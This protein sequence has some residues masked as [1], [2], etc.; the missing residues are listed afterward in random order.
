MKRSVIFVLSAVL[1]TGFAQVAGAQAAAPA[2]VPKIGVVNI[3]RLMQE[4]PQ[5]RSANS[6]L[7]AEFAPEEREIEAL[8]TSLQAKQDKLNK[9]AATMSEMQRNAAERELRDG[10][11]D[12]QARQ[13]KAE[14][15]FTARRNEEMSKLQRVVLEEVQKYART[16]SY[17][18]ILADG[19]LFAAGALDVTGPILQA[20]QS[21]PAGAASPAPAKP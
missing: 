14:D 3:N 5:F 20:L 6:T 8:R 7:Q 16:N 18:L 9:D 4:S 17:D 1:A 19:V 12:L 2:A 10:V 15:K 11:I 21:R 13:E